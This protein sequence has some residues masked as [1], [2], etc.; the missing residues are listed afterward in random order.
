[1][2]IINRN[3]ENRDKYKTFLLPMPM[4]INIREW[5][6]HSKEKFSLYEHVQMIKFRPSQRESNVV[7]LWLSSKRKSS[8]RTMRIERNK[9]YFFCQCLFIYMNGGDIQEKNSIY[10]H[11]Q[12]IRDGSFQRELNAPLLR[13]RTTS[14]LYTERLEEWE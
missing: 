12:M 5:W 7:S 13:P 2:K 6:W 14:K 10:K 9:K 1:M 8:T 4:S 11:V 3:N